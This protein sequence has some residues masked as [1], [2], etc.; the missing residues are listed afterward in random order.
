MSDAVAAETTEQGLK[1]SVT[2]LEPDRFERAVARR[3]AETRATVPTMELSGVV[4]M[5]AATAREAELSCGVAALLIRA[6][7]HGLGAV[8]R[9]NAAYRDGRYELYSRVNVGVTIVEQGVY[10]TPTIFDADEKTELEIA[11]ELAGYYGRA[12][13]GELRPAELTGATFTLVDSSAYE[14]VALSPMIIPPQAAAMASGAIRD[15]PVIRDG[16]VVPGRTMQLALSVD[17]RVVYEYHATA[18]LDEVKAHLERAR[19]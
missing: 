1:G 16:E 13:E 10:V 6:A 19:A 14:I 4:D 15:V 8:P 7:A 11:S 9:V 17:R 12:R 2:V 18:F 5:D 3:S